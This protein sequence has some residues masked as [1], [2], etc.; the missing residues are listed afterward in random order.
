MFCFLD[1]HVEPSFHIFSYI[2]NAK[3]GA[4]VLLSNGYV[5][6]LTTT[7]ISAQLVSVKVVLK[8]GSEGIHGSRK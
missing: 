3:Y 5:Y 7:S 4:A 1:L 6:A 2:S 8:H